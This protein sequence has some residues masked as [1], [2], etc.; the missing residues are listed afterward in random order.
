VGGIAGGAAVGRA[1]GDGCASRVSS[2]VVLALLQ[3]FSELS[4]MGSGLATPMRTT[5]FPK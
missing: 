2:L 5:P 4:V 3:A 1:G